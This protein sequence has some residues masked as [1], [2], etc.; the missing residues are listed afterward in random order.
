MRLSN[1]LQ[2]ATAI[3]L[4][5]QNLNLS[6]NHMITIYKITDFKKD[7]K[8]KKSAKTLFANN[9]DEHGQEDRYT[10]LAHKIKQEGFCDFTSPYIFTHIKAN[11]DTHGAVV[12]KQNVHGFMTSPT[13]LLK[14]L[15]KN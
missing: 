9:T 4:L 5:I 15:I 1:R 8:L 12:I 14:E 6:N 13:S 3:K 11:H 7:G 10:E 2:H